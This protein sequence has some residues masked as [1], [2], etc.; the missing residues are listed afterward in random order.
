MNI[1]I[2]QRIA[3]LKRLRAKALRMNIG[4]QVMQAD[5]LLAMLEA[6]EPDNSYVGSLEEEL[7]NQEF[8]DN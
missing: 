1:T 6:E 2:E 4:F 3:E 8:N 5:A 7:R